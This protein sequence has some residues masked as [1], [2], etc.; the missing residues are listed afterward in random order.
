MKRLFLAVF[1]IVL[2]TLTAW[3]QKTSNP[4]AVDPNTAA[5]KNEAKVQKLR[6]KQQKQRRR[7]LRHHRKHTAA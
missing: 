7:A 2:V 4:R 6:R 5:A 1:A 3:A